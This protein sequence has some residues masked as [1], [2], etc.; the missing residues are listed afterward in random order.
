VLEDKNMKNKMK[1]LAMSFL[2]ISI[3]AQAQTIDPPYS[4]GTGIW[5]QQVG[6]LYPSNPTSATLYYTLYQTNDRVK[7]VDYYYDGNGYLQLSNKVTICRTPDGLVGADGIVHHPDNDLLIAA[8]GS[9][10]HK[11]NKSVGPGNNCLVKTVT[12]NNYTGNYHLMMDPTNEVVWG[13]GI[14]GTLSSYKTVID[15]ANSSLRDGKQVQLKQKVRNDRFDPN[16]LSTIIWDEDGTAFYTYSDYF[17]GGC[18]ASVGG[19]QGVGPCSAEQQKKSRSKAHFGMF[20]DTIPQGAKGSAIDIIQTSILIDSLEGAHG[21]TYDTYSKTIFVFGG[22]KIVQIDPRTRKVVASI[23][24][25][26]YFF[27]ESLDKLTKPRTQEGTYSYVGWRLDQGTVDGLG[28]LFVASNTGHLIFID[29]TSNPNKYI[30]DNIHIHMQWLDNYLDDV[31]PLSGVGSSRHNAST[32]TDE[33][34]SSSSRNYSSSSHALI[35]SSSSVITSSSSGGGTGSSSSGGGT[36]TSSSGGGT[37]SSSSGGGTGTS[38]S[39]GGTGTSSSDGGTGTSSSDG[40]TGTSSSDGGTGTSS[41]DGGTG[42]SSSDGGTGS[43]SSGGGT[44]SSSS[45]GAG[46]GDDLSSSSSSGTGSGSGDDINFSS[47]SSKQYVGFD[48]FDIDDDDDP[49]PYPSDDKREKGDT[50]VIGG[51]VLNPVD[52]E[53]GTPGT[54]TIGG[55]VYDTTLPGSSLDGFGGNTGSEKEAVNVGQVIE[56]TLSGDKLLD[57]LNISSG[58]PIIITGVGGIQIIDPNNPNDPSTKKTIIS[59]GNDVKILITSDSVVMG[60]Q[61][62]VQNELGETVIFDGFNFLD[63]IPDALVGF[64][65]DTEGDGKLDMVEVVLNDP[66]P[67]KMT[68]TAMAIVVNGDTLNVTSVPNLNKDRITVDVTSLNFPDKFPEDAYVIVTYTDTETNTSYKRNASLVEVGGHVIK[69]ANAIR[70]ASGQDSLFI[71]FNIDLLPA[72]VSQADF[73]IMLNKNGF[74]LDQVSS[75]SMPTKNLI[76]ITGD[77]LGLRGADRDSISLYPS[78]SFTNL[79]YMTSDEYSRQIVVKVTDRL[80]TASY[81]E[82]YDTD[83]DGILDQI[84]TVFPDSISE[85]DKNKLYMSFPWYSF[86]GMLIQLQAQPASLE[87]D[88]KDPKRV[89]WNV[90][91]DIKLAT[92]LTSISD[93]MPQATIYTYYD[94]MGYTFVAE[95]TSPIRDKMAPVITAANLRYGDGVDTLIVS[96][97]EIVNSSKLSGK[98]YFSYIHGQDTINLVPSRIEWS[99]DGSS[100]R[101][102]LNTGFNTILPGDSLMMISGKDGSIKDNAG[103]IAGEIPSPVVITGFLNQLVH[104]VKMGSLNSEDETL[105]E[106]SSVSLSYLPSSTRKEDLEEKGV[107]GHLV[108]L[109]QRFVPQL[110]DAA[111][112]DP[113]GEVNPSILDSLDPAKVMLSFSVRY[114]DHVGQYVNDTVISVACNSPKFGGNCLNTDQKLFVNWNFKDRSGRFVG[115]GVYLVQF[116]LVVRY[117][118]K[119]IEEELIDKWGVRRSKKGTVPLNE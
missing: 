58:D 89:I 83:E 44:G 25:R 68:V 10:I 20:S 51:S 30:N 85:E 102:V 13:A 81:V 60:G 70:N 77:S 46:T 115:A 42:N 54:I 23:D 4:A 62:Y 97:S 116:K 35:E 74:D 2:L 26:Q 29:Y 43:S 114:F 22:S 91:S 15:P 36:G 6:T 37:G 19:V 71:E 76:I 14:P 59:S 17:G 75:V 87:I 88:P 69:Q 105:R 109:G 18:E 82:Y 16:R 38:S 94:V 90:Q 32:G 100:A 63:P 56:V 33:E 117:E 40:G 41:S 66:L 92:G 93:E 24:L 21:G 1:L 64:I 111:Q 79:P 84:V 95:N 49:L 106:L 98:D 118:N 5:I 86:R 110:I 99:N 39:D 34:Y 67:S 27:I 11:V 7:S 80:P 104:S 45:G 119:R 9:K 50:L 96:F 48:D 72:D 8:Q 28:H 107:L 103:N 12:G 73:I 112:V 113:N 31:A 101:L 61:I 65:K 3:G 47:S 53:P 55:N 78:V 108:E 57:Y 52:A